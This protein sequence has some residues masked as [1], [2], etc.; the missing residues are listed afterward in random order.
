MK[1]FR[2]LMRYVQEIGVRDDNPLLEMMITSP[3]SRE[4]VWTE[5]ELEKVVK[6]LIS[7]S[8]ATSGN[9]IPPR[10]SIALAALIAYDTS[11]PQQDIL[12][13]R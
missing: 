12:A 6:L 1:W 4:E 13:L 2:R 11:L 7:G 5:K 8:T 3:T 9:K 10:P